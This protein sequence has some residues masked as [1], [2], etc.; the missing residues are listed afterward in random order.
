MLRKAIRVV[1]KNI[2]RLVII[3]F[4]LFFLICFYAMYD[5]LM[6]YNHANDESALKYKPSSGDDAYKLGELSKD[7]VAWI[8]V[9]KTNIDYPVMQ[10]K[11][12]SEYLNKNPYGKYSLS[13]SIFLDSN[14]DRHFKDEYSLLYG[15][16]MDYGSMFGALDEFIKPKYFNSHRTGKLITLGGDK[17]NI[18]FFASLKAQATEKVIFDVDYSNNNELIVYLKKNAKIFKKPTNDKLHL[19]ALSTCQSADSDERMIVVGTLDLT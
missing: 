12:N 3:V 8:T 19:I 4:L 14:C 9:D 16:H 11:N 13:G 15:H 5:A 7:A 17:Y 1:D 18:T 6:V 2:D 10:G